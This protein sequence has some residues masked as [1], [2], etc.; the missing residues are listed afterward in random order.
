MI[1]V[2][3]ICKKYK[4]HT[5]LD[6]V[7][8]EIHS[9]DC[10]GIIGAN[11]SGKT[12][13]VSIISG[14]NSADSGEI[15][16]DGTVI[17]GAK[18]KTLGHISYVPQENPLI[19]ELSAFDNLRLW[20]KGS[21]K[22][23]KKELTSG[24]ISSLDIDSYKH[25]TVAKL[26]GGM[27]KRLNI[28]IALLDH[29][30]LLIMDEPSAALDLAGKYQI[31]EYMKEFTRTNNGSILVVSHDLTELAVCNRLYCLKNGQLHPVPD[32]YKDEDIMEM[33]RATSKG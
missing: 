13:L 26:S 20:Y 29:P 22:E 27:K 19:E 11:G 25:K 15:L 14:I 31:R 1:E 21:K 16:S 2:K 7:S 18:R 17:S 32:T 8:L 9:G 24:S 5:V 28:A 6:N 23:L 4:K 10:I 12:T 33:L 30:K 3:N